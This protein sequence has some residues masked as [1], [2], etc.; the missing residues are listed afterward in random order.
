MVEDV[1]QSIIEAE[2]DKLSRKKSEMSAEA[3]EQL[4]TNLL[5]NEKIL[6][7]IYDKTFY[8][9]GNKALQDIELPAELKR[10]L[11]DKEAEGFD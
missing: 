10:I 8:S 4:L 9:G 2:K 7:L 3:R 6:T 5:A 1:R 11:E